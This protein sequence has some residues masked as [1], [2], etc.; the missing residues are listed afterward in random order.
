M[1]M[2]TWDALVKAYPALG[3]TVRDESPL[4][5]AVELF[6][7]GECATKITKKDL[8]ADECYVAPEVSPLDVTCWNC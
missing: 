1:D 8:A 5:N 2:S 6:F 3:T 7:A 4:R